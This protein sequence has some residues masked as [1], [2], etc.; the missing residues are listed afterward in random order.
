MWLAALVLCGFS[1]DTA[2]GDNATKPVWKKLHKMAI[3]AV[4]AAAAAGADGR[5]YVIGG[6]TNYDSTSSLAATRIFDPKNDAWTEGASM[7]TARSCPGA[8]TGPDGRIYVVGGQIGRRALD[9]VEAYDPQENLW[10]HCS[11][12]PSARTDPS[13]VAARDGSGHF[14]IYSIG[15]RDFRSPGNGL[16]AVEAYDPVT[17]TWSTKTPMPTLRHAQTEAVSSSGLVYII[18]GAH[19]GEPQFLNTVE[20]YDPVRDKWSAV[21]PLPYPI[22]CAMATGGGEILVFG[23]WKTPQKDEARHVVAFNP[24]SGAWGHL[25]DMPTARAAGNAVSV[26]EADGTAHIYLLGGKDS[27][28]SVDEC[29]IPRPKTRL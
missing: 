24:R 17:D 14:R 21:K 18:G 29:A 1:A 20:V 25:P 3:P 26:Q 22:E 11:P 27:E 5:I 7:P 19:M 12:M 2:P 4:F 6:Q 9:V 28:V 23:G 10:T 8:A 13:V 16:A 15:G